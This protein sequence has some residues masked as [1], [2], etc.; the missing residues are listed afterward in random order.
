M[1]PKASISGAS[2]V[3]VFSIGEPGS[4][5]PVV[6][7]QSDQAFEVLYRAIV[8]CEIMPGA[9]VSEAQLA[10]RFGLARASARAAV[11]RLSIVGMLRPVHRRGYIV[12][13]ITLRDVNDLFQLRTIIE[14]AANRLAAGRV[15]EFSLRR[16]Q[17][18]LLH[19]FLHVGDDLGQLR[20]GFVLGAWCR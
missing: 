7:R 15:D 11:D 13:P 2:P 9:T 5:A 14:V 12:K 19:R 4:R 8:R 10:E 6:K 17:Q 18:P 16:L 1:K 3:P 20:V